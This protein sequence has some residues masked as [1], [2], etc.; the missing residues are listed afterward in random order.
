MRKARYWGEFR[1]FVCY[2]GTWLEMNS[3]V[4]SKVILSY[5]HSADE[6]IENPQFEC[7]VTLYVQSYTRGERDCSILLT[8]IRLYTAHHCQAGVM[9]RQ[10][11]ERLVKY[12]QLVQIADFV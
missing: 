3:A 11:D 6:A 9:D 4:N 5:I 1:G 2:G 8:Y 12:F 7:S 10:T